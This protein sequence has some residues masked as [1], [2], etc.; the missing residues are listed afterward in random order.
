MRADDNHLSLMRTQVVEAARALSGE[1]GYAAS[2]GQRPA[3]AAS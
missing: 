2:Q 1:F 3:T